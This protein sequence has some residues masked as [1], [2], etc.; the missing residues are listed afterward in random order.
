MQRIFQTFGLMSIILLTNGLIAS[1]NASARIAIF[2]NQLQFNSIQNV[3]TLQLLETDSSGVMTSDLTTQA[4]WQVEPANLAVIGENQVL[5][6][7][8]AGR[9][10]VKARLKDGREFVADLVIT[11]QPA[12]QVEWS[13]LNHVQPVLTKTGCNSGPC[14]GSAAGKNGFRLSLRGYAPEMDYQALTRQAGGRRLVVGHPERSLMLWKATG[15]VAHGGGSR[16]APGTRNYE[17]LAGWIANGASGLTK[18]TPVIESLEVSPKLARLSSGASSRVVVHAIYSD[19]TRTDVT[20]WAKF[21]TT[22]ET[23]LKV[24][25]EGDFSAQNSGEA[26][27]SVW[28]DSLVETVTVTVPSGNTVTPEIF[29]NAPRNNRIDEFNLNKLKSLGIPPSP[30]AGDATWLRRIYL[31]LTGLLPDLKTTTEFLAEKSPDKRAKVIDKLLGSQEF[32]DYWAYQWSDLLLVSSQ[33]LPTPAMWSFYQYVRES[34]SEN[35]PWDEFVRGIITARGGTLEN[36]AGNYFVLHRDPTDLT[37][38]TSVAF[39]GLSLTCARCHN[40]PL[41][42]WTQDQYYGFASLLSRVGLKDGEVSGEVIVSDRPDGEILHPRKGRPM[43]PQPLDAQAMTSDSDLSR[44]EVLADWIT[45]DDNP[46]F[47]RA[48]INRVWKK[49]L[50]RGMMEPED[51]LRATNPAMDEP[52]LEWLETDLISH[53]FDVRH[54]IKMIASSALYARSS[55]PLPENVSDNRFFS[56]ALPR[57]LP[58][59]VLLDIYSQTTGVDSNFPGFPEKWRALQ[60]P[61]SKVANG[62]LSAFGRPERIST[63]SCERSNEPSIA[64]ALHL[65]NGETLNG[66]LKSDSGTVSQ[67]SSSNES[68]TK[69]IRDLFLMTLTREPTA[70]EQKSLEKLLIET[71]KAGKTKESAA[72]LRREAWEDIFWAILTSDEFLFTH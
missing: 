48:L 4:N 33:K 12:D 56:H 37:E 3:E 63:C 57:R 44:R 13:F 14:H 61:D 18:E 60:L 58:A 35:R 70:N 5:T 8:K 46:L 69:L 11:D 1:E 54:L 26:F 49:L 53:G 43:P 6:P 25:E 28:F 67:W 15:A 31:D 39:L 62:F 51:D 59:E 24:G 17:I 27:V 29:A 65:A 55:Q 66:K 64:Q 40:H 21:S 38:T 71:R 42:K 36:G 52:M 22:D 45:G 50:G 9:G 2:P 23:V 68:D 30:D 72:S 7:A 41:E 47:A 10:R 34:V 20:D 19:G 32:I 16:I